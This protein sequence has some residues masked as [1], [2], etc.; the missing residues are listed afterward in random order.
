MTS[1][2]RFVSSKV[3]Q[4]EYLTAEAEADLV[5]RRDEGDL[6]A[7]DELVLRGLPLA[8]K[9]ILVSVQKNPRWE[10]DL[11]SAGL[12]GLVSAADNFRLEEGCR[13]T[14]YATVCVRRQIQL[15]HERE[16]RTIHIPPAILRFKACLDRMGSPA[17][18]YTPS[19]RTLELVEIAKTANSFGQS[20]LG[21]HSNPLSLAEIQTSSN[22]IREDQE[23]I[24]KAL[25]TLNDRLANIVRLR[26]FED[27][28]QAE[29]GRQYGLT[30]SRVQQLEAQAIKDLRKALES[31]S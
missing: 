9:I 18:S 29:I 21:S 3:G 17:K 27:M 22:S 20:G 24:G 10:D 28:S 7:R 1:A 12:L 6:S 25:A 8:R 15:A 11:A 14:T 19:P 5:R 30:R 23:A 2:I 26:Y 4:V 31:L 16:T 13:F